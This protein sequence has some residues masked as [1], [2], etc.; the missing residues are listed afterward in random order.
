MKEALE[1][2]DLFA[3]YNL[4]EKAIAELEKVLQ[5]YPDQIE[6]HRRILEIS[7]KGFP[8]RGAVA[9]AQLARIFTEL[10]DV[11]D[12]ETNTKPSR[13]RMALAGDSAASAPHSTEGGRAS[14]ASPA[15]PRMAGS[16]NTAMEFPIP[17]IAPE[18]PLTASPP[19]CRQKSLLILRL[20][21]FRANLRLCHPNPQSRLCRRWSWISR[22]NWR[23]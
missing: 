4:T 8:E 21:Q 3:R 23:P 14:A 20:P 11:G 19:Q 2:S 22:E 10:G 17:A 12:G 13:Q 15:C 1:N 7:R 5:V 16:G 6:V 18:E 9:A